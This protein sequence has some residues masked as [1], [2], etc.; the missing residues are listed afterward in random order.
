[1]EI[2]VDFHI[3]SKYSRATSKDMDV[4]HLSSSA[5]M[6]GIHVVGTGDFTHPQWL[7]E[8]KNSLGKYAN[9]IYEKDGTCF[10]LTAEVNNI[11]TKAQKTRRVHNVLIAPSFDIV[12]EINK[13]LSEYGDLFADGRPILKLDA[14]K[15]LQILRSI[16][17]DV[18]VIPAHLWTPWFGLLGSAT[19]FN[20]VEECFEEETPNICAVET[21]L[22][23]DPAMNWRLSQL[24][25][26]ALISN[27]DAHSPKNLG[28][29]ANV[30]NCEVDYYEIMKSIKE[31]NNKK[32]LYTIEF[33][34][35]EGKYH[36]DGHRT[37]GQCLA[38]KESIRHGNVCPVCKKKL[39]IGVMHRVEE[40]ADRPEEYKDNN[41]VPFKSLI[42]LR[43]IIAEAK[44]VGADSKTVQSE[45]NQVIAR[46]GSEFN[47]L[48]KKTREELQTFCNSK[49]TEG[50]LKVREGNV[51]IKPG[52]DGE[53][54]KVS[55]FNN[56]VSSGEQQLTLF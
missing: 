5:K 23:S 18:Y 20:S 36:Y 17:Q 45:Y 27:S 2:V 22:S 3:H 49:V 31:R 43:E 21:G 39:T 54:G 55:I 24:D 9:G 16:S 42:P 11:Y 30:F 48:L 37:C 19:G 33:F 34:P 29:E 25:N 28:R 41:F 40:L 52:Y 44:Q 15:M 50:I 14:K 46:A 7:L 13:A 38:P 1:M 10:I 56:E 6:K 12:K 4:E 26:F 8:L 51:S 35:Q 32:F 47:A 53:Y